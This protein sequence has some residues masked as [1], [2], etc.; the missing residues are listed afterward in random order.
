MLKTLAKQIGE[1]KRAA[2]LT[3]VFMIG[4]VLMEVLIPYITANLIDEGIEKGYSLAE[5][6]E[7][8]AADKKKFEAAERIR[9]ILREFAGFLDKEDYGSFNTAIKRELIGFNTF[10]SLYGMDPPLLETV[11]G[12]TYGMIGLYPS[13]GLYAV[14][15]GEY[16]GTQR[17]GTGIYAMYAEA[18]SGNTAEY[19][20]KGE[21]KNDAPNGQFS[22]YKKI[23][24]GN[25][26]VREES[27]TVTV[28][29]GI[30]DGEIALVRDGITF[31]GSFKNGIVT[32]ID[33]KD[34]NGEANRVT[35]YSKDKKYF[36]YYPN[37][38]AYSTVF[39][40]PGYGQ[41]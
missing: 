19:H 40:V 7:R 25:Q 15:Y 37:A 27:T 3:P 24:S 23:C 20:G 5:D 38:A 22:E 32:V 26:V 34:P 35:M 28:K 10:E 41:Y 9:S 16:N 36:L 33:E 31:Y 8:I 39:G 29:D 4:E 11:E 14:Y 12:G 17:E 2:I 30:Y 21:W 6:R 1:Y 18:A 13:E